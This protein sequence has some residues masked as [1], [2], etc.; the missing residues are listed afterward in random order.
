MQILDSKIHLLSNSLFHCPQQAFTA[1][2]VFLLICLRT[3][4]TGTLLFK[5]YKTYFFIFYRLGSR[6]QFAVFNFI[7][8]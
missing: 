5:T 7:T 3:Y 4:S 1:F 2:S 8:P 6:M